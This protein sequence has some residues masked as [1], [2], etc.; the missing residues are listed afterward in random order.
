MS[1][2]CKRGIVSTH[3]IL[4]LALALPVLA[5]ETGRIAG[6]VT[7]STG[8]VPFQEYGVTAELSIRANF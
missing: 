1:S 2:R 7:D 8:D 5:Q 6:R 4:V 3:L